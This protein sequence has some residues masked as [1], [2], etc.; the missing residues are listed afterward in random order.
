MCQFVAVILLIGLL[1]A[2]VVEFLFFSRRVRHTWCALVTGVQTCALPIL[3]GSGPPLPAT[4]E[5]IEV[6]AADGVRLRGVRIP[7]RRPRTGE[8]LILLGFGGNA[9]N[10]DNVALYLHDLFPEAEAVAFHYRGYLPSAG[11]PSAAALLA[12]APSLY[13]HIVG[14]RQRT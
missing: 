9:W 11:R 2:Y 6:A 5:R 14:E 8:R 10:A 12:D 4:A 3:A 13:D 7:P 1:S